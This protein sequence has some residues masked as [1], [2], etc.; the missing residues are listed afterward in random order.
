MKGE[1]P[2]WERLW[3]STWFFSMRTFRIAVLIAAVI[4]ACTCV[5]LADHTLRDLVAKDVV[6]TIQDVRERAARRLYG[7][8]ADLARRISAY[9]S[10]EDD[11]PPPAWAVRGSAEK[12]IP[13]AETIPL[14]LRDE[15]LE[16]SREADRLEGD[17]SP[18]EVRGRSAHDTSR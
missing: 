5:N 13:A 11:P 8:T 15:Q 6:D 7:R 2:L 4:L 1:S 14:I 17:R 12:V 16:T 9:R 18:G 3:G 10:S